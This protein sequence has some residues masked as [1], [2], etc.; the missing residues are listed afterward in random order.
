MYAHGL[1][2]FCSKFGAVCLTSPVRKLLSNYERLDGNESTASFDLVTKLHVLH[3]S[4]WAMPHWSDERKL[5]CWTMFLVSMCLMARAS[6]VTCFCPLFENITMPLPNM[7]DA[8]GYPA[9]IKVALLDWKHRSMKNKGKRYEMRIWRNPIDAKY[10]PVF[11]IMKWLSY[12]GICAGPIFQ[13]PSSKGFTGVAVTRGQW[14]TMTTRLFT[15][16][17]KL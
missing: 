15:E 11:Y 17:S 13:M 2:S 10:C 5:L 6:D 7:W 9:Y 12:S 14:R 3:C 4:C 8:D 1:Q 16:V